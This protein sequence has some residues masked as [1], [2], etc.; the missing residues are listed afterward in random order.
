MPEGF[1]A[2]AN[3]FYDGRGQLDQLDRELF[4]LTSPSEDSLRL[5]YRPGP[6]HAW[7]E[8]PTYFKNQLNSDVDRFGF[9][10]IDHIAPGEYTFAKGISTVSAPEVQQGTFTAKASPNPARREIRVQAEELFQHAMLF[11]ADGA[12][13]KEWSFAACK[14]IELKISGLA[15][16]NYRL[17][18]SGKKG[19]AACPIVV[20]R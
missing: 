19:S 1:D 12:L 6:G 7:Q 20:L 10:R 18:L 8:Y 13:T 17:I 4:V 14:E 11:S 3:I 16:G 9:I 15:A 2:S 5:I